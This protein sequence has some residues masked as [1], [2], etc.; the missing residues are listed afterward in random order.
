MGGIE[1]GIASV[2]VIVFLIYMGLY[3]PVALGLVSVRG[4]VADPRQSGYRG[5]AAVGIDCGYG[6]GAGFRIGAAFCPDGA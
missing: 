4:C 6:V 1:V 2:A 5:R 3:I